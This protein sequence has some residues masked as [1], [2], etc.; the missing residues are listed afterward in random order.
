MIK[1]IVAVILICSC[2]SALGCKKTVNTLEVG[3]ESVIAEVT[4]EQ[5]LSYEEIGNKAVEE[6]G[7]VTDDIKN[8]KRKEA[9][10]NAIIENEGK[11]I[12]KSIS[13]TREEAI[14]ELNKN[15]RPEIK[16]VIDVEIECNEEGHNHEGEDV[17]IDTYYVYEGDNSFDNIDLKDAFKNARNVNR[18][19]A[20]YEDNIEEMKRCLASE[21]LVKIVES[22]VEKVLS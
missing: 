16:E 19:D 1:K 20:T 17:D 14:N 5:K 6:L 3:N 11:D 18:R 4:E 12:M 13:I 9:I 8:E 7:D 22:K 21:E 15:L 10:Y 2:T